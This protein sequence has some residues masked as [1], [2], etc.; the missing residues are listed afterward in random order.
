MK[1]LPRIVGF[2]SIIAGLI[3]IVAGGATWYLVQS[4]PVR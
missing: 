2:I 4:R 1:K 3:M